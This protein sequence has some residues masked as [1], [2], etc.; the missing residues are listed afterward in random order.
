MI[1]TE[2]TTLKVTRPLALKTKP[3]GDLFDVEGWVIAEEG[4]PPKHNNGVLAVDTYLIYRGS[5]DGDHIFLVGCPVREFTLLDNLNPII[6]GP[7]EAECAEFTYDE[8]RYLAQLG[9]LTPV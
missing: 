8:V 2:H 3:H 9:A 5:K 1:A 4:I 7:D 6:I